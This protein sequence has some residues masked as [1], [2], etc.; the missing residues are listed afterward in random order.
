ML[1]LFQ[2][3]HLLGRLVLRINLLQLRCKLLGC[4]GVILVDEVVGDEVTVS[5]D[6]TH[7]IGVVAIGLAA[8]QLYELLVVGLA[9][10]SFD[11]G[12]ICM[13]MRARWKAT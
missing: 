9:S 3:K 7:L 11:S 6:E 10:S 4:S 5:L 8:Q 13:P 2:L 1:V 12:S